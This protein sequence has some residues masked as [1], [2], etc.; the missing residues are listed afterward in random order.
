VSGEKYIM[1][2]LLLTKCFSGDKIKKNGMGGTC[3]IYGGERGVY[4]ILV[5]KPE[6]K[7]HL[8]DVGVDRKIMLRWI[9]RQWDGGQ[10]LD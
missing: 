7:D 4:R 8:E 6:E 3:S 9:Y 10:R 1:K 5:G 2:S